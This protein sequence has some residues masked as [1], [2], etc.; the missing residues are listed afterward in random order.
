MITPRHAPRAPF[1]ARGGLL[2]KEPERQVHRPRS[3]PAGLAGANKPAQGHTPRRTSE[4]CEPSAAPPRHLTAG[5]FGPW[6]NLGAPWCWWAGGGRTAPGSRVLPEL[7]RRSQ[8]WPVAGTE[9]EVGPP[10]FS[11]LVRFPTSPVGAAGVRGLPGGRS[12]RAERP[13]RS[14]SPRARAPA[15]AAAAAAATTS[16]GGISARRL[17]RPG[18]RLARRRRARAARAARPRCPEARE[19]RPAGAGG[20]EARP[21]LGA[22]RRDPGPRCPRAARLDWT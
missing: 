9:R 1:W 6:R 4:Q 17:G 19:Q 11:Q 21:G 12:G 20:G 18:T 5:P 15:P 14:Q 13:P 7:G 10:A 2:G 8:R 3:T 22:R 16:G